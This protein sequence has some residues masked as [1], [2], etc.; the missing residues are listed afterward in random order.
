[1]LRGLCTFIC[2][3]YALETNAGVF[4]QSIRIESGTYGANCGA[5][6]GNV[7]RDLAAHCDSL[8]TCRYVIDATAIDGRQNDCAADLVTEWYCGPN[9]RHIATARADTNNG[10]SLVLTCVQ[11]MG[12]GK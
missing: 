9:E 8:A 1:M 2:I 11:S 7:T 12:A 3:A 5:R 6:Q 10:S 4:A